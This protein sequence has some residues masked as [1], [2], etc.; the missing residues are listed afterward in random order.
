MGRLYDELRITDTVEIRLV[1]LEGI[2]EVTDRVVCRLD[3]VP[4]SDSLKYRALSYCWGDA[5]PPALVECNGFQLR[6]TENLT[7]ALKCLLR[8]RNGKPLSDFLTFW[9]DAICINQENIMERA[10]Q[11]TLMGNIYRQAKEVVVWLGPAADHSDLAFRACQRLYDE[12]LRRKTGLSSA[13]EMKYKVAKGVRWSSMES[14]AHIIYDEKGRLSS[15]AITAYIRELDA[16]HAILRRPWWTRVWII[17]EITLARELVVLCGHDSISWH[18]L[19]VGINACMQRPFSADF[20]ALATVHYANML[21]QIRH[22]VIYSKGAVTQPT[23]SLTHLLGRFRWSKATNARDKIY[24]LLG[25]VAAGRDGPLT[26]L[27]YSQDVEKCYRDAII[28]IIKSSGTLDILQLSR[29]P[30]S[31]GTVSAQ[32]TLDL[33]SWVPFLQLDADDVD[34]AVDLSKLG[35]VGVQSW[36]DI[37]K[38]CSA[39]NPWNKQWRSLCF[40]ASGDSRIARD[41]VESKEDNVLV[42]RGFVFDKVQTMGE[43][44]TGIK[45]QG[46]PLLHQQYL[47][48]RRATVEAENIRFAVKAARSLLKASTRR[49]C[50]DVFQ[51]Q[52]HHVCKTLAENNIVKTVWQASWTGLGGNFHNFCQFGQEKLRITE[53]K[54]L[55]LS[56]QGAYPTEETPMQ[57]FVGTMYEG[58]LGTDPE[59]MMKQYEVELRRVLSKVET[60]DRGYLVRRLRPQSRLRHVLAGLICCISTLFKIEEIDFIGQAMYKCFSITKQGYFALVP[61]ETREGDSIALLKGGQVP[62]VL[63]HTLKSGIAGWELI[64]PCYVHGIMHGEQWDEGQCQPMRLV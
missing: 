47:H 31:L 13:K 28:D 22:A 37:D 52:F 32:N 38:L 19:D 60:L 20:L 39:E 64:G 46:N 10:H 40:S 29:K 41:D 61:P 15:R 25:L 43:A 18:T 55:A 12:D 48:I 44:Q 62:F 58:G 36:P 8:N 3:T 16:I 27:S 23:Y 42:I 11:V 30:P 24:G 49:E 59:E 34:P 63:R 50:V 5:E 53:W 51:E 26:N 17:Q 57:A 7:A 54:R 2:D 21:F 14:Y 56:Q 9:I 33:P 35:A 4:L 1:T 45:A 6:V